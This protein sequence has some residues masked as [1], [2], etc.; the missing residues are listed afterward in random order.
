M[1]EGPTAGPSRVVRANLLALAA[2][3][4]MGAGVLLWQQPWRPSSSVDDVSYPD[5]PA[6]VIDQQLRA[7]SDAT[8]EELVTAAG[9]TETARTAAAALDLL[10]GQKVRF[11]Y[12]DGGQAPTRDDGSTTVTVR[13]TWQTDGSVLPAAERASEVQLV[14]RPD[15]D[16]FAWAGTDHRGGEPLPLWLAGE[17]AV[18]A[19]ADAVVVALEDASDD[20]GELAP[21]AT[22]AAQRAREELGETA[23]DRLVL[24]VPPTDAALGRLAGRAPDEAAAIAAVTTRLDATSD[25]GAVV[26]LNPAVFAEMDERGRRIVLVHEAVH[27]LTRVVGSRVE[28]WV[29]EGYADE[30]AL[31]GDAAGLETSAGRILAEVRREG[32]PA[33][34]PGPQDFGDAERVT[35]VYESAWL[36]IRMLV[37]E[38]GDERVREF[39][40]AVVAGAEVDVALREMLGTDLASVTARWQDYLVALAS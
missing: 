16:R 24:V 13:V 23:A 40:D 6:R 10:G 37:E 11:G 22:A 1:P 20:M 39:Y 9:G 30:I 7:M 3:I 26:A 32:P 25:A 15:G 34:L 29:A 17:I 35:A 18:D 5:D 36:A 28:M 4:V 27:Q 12:V 21:I 8:G 19:D 2:L 14:M 38:Y 31:R 33:A